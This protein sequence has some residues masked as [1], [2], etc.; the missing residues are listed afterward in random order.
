MRVS[1]LKEAVVNANIPQWSKRNRVWIGLIVLVVI[2]GVTYLVLTLAL[3]RAP[4]TLDQAVV[5]TGTMADTEFHWALKPLWWKNKNDAHS[6]FAGGEM[7]NDTTSP[8]RLYG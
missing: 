8:L 1:V 4:P 6:T 3:P 7:R 5:P 2:G